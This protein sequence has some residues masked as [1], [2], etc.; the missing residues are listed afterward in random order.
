MKLLS[1]LA[2]VPYLVL[3]TGLVAA[4]PVPQGDSE[5]SAAPLVTFRAADSLLANVDT[6]RLAVVA[7]T[8]LRLTV[9][10]HA[11]RA[12]Q[13][14]SGPPSDLQTGPAHDPWGVGYNPQPGASVSISLPDAVLTCIHRILDFPA[15]PPFGAR[16]RFGA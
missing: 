4:T 3:F 9:H 16:E 8:S 15:A 12:G 14:A 5:P 6:V 11:G 1:S 10:V 2:L 13:P 7:E